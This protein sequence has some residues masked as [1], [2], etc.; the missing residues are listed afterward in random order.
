MAEGARGIKLPK[1]LERL[2]PRVNNGLRSPCT[3]LDFEYR[4]VDIFR[5]LNHCSHAGGIRFNLNWLHSKDIVDAIDITGRTGVS[6]YFQLAISDG[7]VIRIGDMKG[8]R[9][10]LERETF[11]GRWSGELDILRSL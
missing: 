11:L 5:L 8:G 2:H 4:T 10:G 7:K 9:I 6:R 1:F 3:S